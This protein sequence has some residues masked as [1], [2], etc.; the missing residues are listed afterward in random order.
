[1]RQIRKLEAPGF[2]PLSQPSVQIQIFLIIS[3]M[4]CTLKLRFNT[5]LQFFS[6][7][8]TISLL[9]SPFHFHVAVK[10]H[11]FPACHCILH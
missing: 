3:G 9:H 1:M 7:L 11:L 8:I 2:A 10:M 4:L 6:I 5:W